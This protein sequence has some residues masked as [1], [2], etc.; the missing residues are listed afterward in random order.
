ML[1]WERVGRHETFSVCM[2]LVSERSERDTFRG[3]QIR[4]GAVY[5]SESAVALSI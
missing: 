3:V 5:I 2:L 1:V 4:A